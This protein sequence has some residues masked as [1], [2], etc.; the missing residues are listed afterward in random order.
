M[1]V[2]L[3][4]RWSGGQPDAMLAAAKKAKA[5]WVRHGAETAIFSQVF[6][7]AFVGDHLFVV[8]FADWPSYARAKDGIDGDAAFQALLREVSGQARLADRTLAVRTEI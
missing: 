6:T 2:T 8:H 3:I 7:G 1:G 4:T 5:A